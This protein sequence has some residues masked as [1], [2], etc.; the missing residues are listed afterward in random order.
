[1]R[2]RQT[3]RSLAVFML[4]LLVF[5]LFLIMTDPNDIPVGVLTFPVINIFLLGFVGAQLF[6]NVFRLFDGHPK[7]R[8]GFATIIA[9][10]LGIALILGSSGAI[11]LGDV[12]IIFLIL[13]VALVY[14]SNF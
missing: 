8:R 2:S 14:I 7:K 6:S 4:L 12:I 1:M 5:V 11:V 13:M 9:T 3:I 10:L